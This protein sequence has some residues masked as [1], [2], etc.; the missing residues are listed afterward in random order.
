MVQ[1]ASRKRADAVEPALPFTDFI[2]VYNLN[3]LVAI[4]PRRKHCSAETNSWYI[5]YVINRS[6]GISIHFTRLLDR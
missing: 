5:L 2:F 6:G 4:V 1:A 3:Y